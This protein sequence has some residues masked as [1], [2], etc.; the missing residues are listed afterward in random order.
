VKCQEDGELLW[1]VIVE[2]N[3]YSQEEP[4]IKSLMYGIRLQCDYVE[5]MASGMVI[6]REVCGECDE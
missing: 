4:S 2:M 6:G 3:A 5:P 1:G